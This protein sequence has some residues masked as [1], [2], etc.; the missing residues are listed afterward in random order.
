MKPK[1][2]LY[3]RILSYNGPRLVKTSKFDK[4][5]TFLKKVEFYTNF[6]NFWP[7]KIRFIYQFKKLV[8]EFMKSCR[9]LIVNA[10][11]NKLM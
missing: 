7:V 11:E 2:N 5:G 8:G 9:N 10:L 4:M 3:W 1:K 6:G